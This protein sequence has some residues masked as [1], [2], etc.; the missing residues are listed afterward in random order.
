MG[1]AGSGVLASPVVVW[2]AGE[3]F[4]ILTVLL[5]RGPSYLPYVNATI[6]P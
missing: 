1:S 6:R 5:V 3:V 4:D 2:L